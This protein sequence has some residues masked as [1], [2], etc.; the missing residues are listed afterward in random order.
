MFSFG[1]IS[2]P[3]SQI[4]FRSRLSVGFVNIKPVLPGHVLV[5]PLRL[6]ERFAELTPNE[7]SDLWLSAQQIGQVVQREFNGTSLS[8]TVQDGPEAGQTVPHVHIHIL[9][10]FARPT[11]RK[12]TVA[13]RKGRRFQAE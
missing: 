12:P 3:A 6:V 5:S 1:R 4:F 8:F 13:H 2:I 10:R 7:V 9:P 11:M